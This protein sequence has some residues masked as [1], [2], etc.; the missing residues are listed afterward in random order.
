VLT[1]RTTASAPPLPPA[2]GLR[3]TAALPNPPGDDAAFEEVHLK[4]LSAAP[5]PLDG[6][7]IT[8]G[9]GQ[10]EWLLNAQDG[11][12]GAGQTTVIVR[13]GRPMSLRNNGDSIG[14]LNPAGLTVATRSY[15]AA[16][17]GVLFTFE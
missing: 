17:S 11:V 6:W 7:R 2:G 4:N 13:R 9:Q 1:L 15:G 3:I 12:V 5:I 14:L 16:A 10:P 8:N